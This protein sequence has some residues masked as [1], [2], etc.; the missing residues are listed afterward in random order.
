[1][2]LLD[3]DGVTIT[4]SDVIS[5]PV[6]QVLYDSGIAPAEDV[7][8]EALSAGWGTDGNQFEFND[9][10][11]QFNLKTKNYTASG[12]YT[13]SIVSGDSGEYVIDPAVEAQFVIP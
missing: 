5:P 10:V 11:W 6:I 8:G 12:T 7:T 3:G 4:D 2:E 9:P 1:M 13:V